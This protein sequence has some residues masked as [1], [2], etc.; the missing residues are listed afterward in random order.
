MTVGLQVVGDSGIFQIDGTYRNLQAISSGSVTTTGSTGVSGSFYSFAARSDL[1]SPVMVIG[2]TNYGYVGRTY[3]GGLWYFSIILNAPVGTSVPYWLFDQP[4]QS[5]PAH[6]YGLQVLDGSGAVLFD[7]TYA[8]MHVAGMGDV[9]SAGTF[10]TGATGRTY[11]VGDLRPGFRSVTL[12]GYFRAQS[13]RINGA[14]ADMAYMN[15][16]TLPASPVQNAVRTGSAIV[17]DVT[18]Y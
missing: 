8:P 17:I 2:G 3:S 13:Y 7:S 16:N 18:G 12:E 5:P 1:V 6:G 15:L 11:A 4:P 10:F 14:N 9:S